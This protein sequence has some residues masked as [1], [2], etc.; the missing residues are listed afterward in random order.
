MRR[1]STQGLAIASALLRRHAAVLCVAAVV[2]ALPLTGFGQPSARTYAGSDQSAQATPIGGDLECPDPA[3]EEDNVAVAAVADRLAFKRSPEPAL[4][5]ATGA[6]G[7]DLLLQMGQSSSFV[8]AYPPVGQRV[9]LSGEF[10]AGYFNEYTFT[11]FG[12]VVKNGGVI[13]ISCAALTLTKTTATGN[14]TIVLNVK[15]RVKDINQPAYGVN[16]VCPRGSFGCGTYT[17]VLAG[18]GELQGVR[19]KGTISPRAFIVNGQGGRAIL[20]SF[21]NT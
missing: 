3:I 4:T 7:A 16:D 11:G 5:G 1:S 12:T 21:T 6:A 15:F 2:L 9:A 14:S 19:V 18:T 13:G 10:D 8:M 17:T 20:G